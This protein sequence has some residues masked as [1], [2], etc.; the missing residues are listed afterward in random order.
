MLMVARHSFWFD[1]YFVPE[2]RVGFLVIG[3]D[4]FTSLMK[5][6]FA[7]VLLV[8][9][10]TCLLFVLCF[11]LAS[12]HI[13]LILPPFTVSNEVI[14]SGIDVAYLACRPHTKQHM[15]VYPRVTPADPTMC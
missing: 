4:E 15:C 13:F 1:S 12:V 14:V 5:L 11:L 6:C 10:K 3:E 7:G 9:R 2:H 8:F